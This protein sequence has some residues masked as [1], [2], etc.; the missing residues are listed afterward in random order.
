MAS[1]SINRHPGSLH[2]SHWGHWPCRR[3]LAALDPLFGRVACRTYLM[4]FCIVGTIKIQ[5]HLF[6]NQPSC[7][8]PSKGKRSILSHFCSQ[9]VG[10]KRPDSCS[11]PAPRL[12]CDL[13][14]NHCSVPFLPR[15]AVKW[16]DLPAHQRQRWLPSYSLRQQPPRPPCTFAR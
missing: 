14:A 13:Q 12:P 9:G 7:T 3:K 4:L 11:P 1:R 8:G 16:V 15:F 2:S 6:A 10:C 5:L